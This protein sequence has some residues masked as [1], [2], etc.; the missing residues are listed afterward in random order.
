MST[1]NLLTGLFIFHTFKGMYLP[2]TCKTTNGVTPCECMQCHKGVSTL[3]PIEFATLQISINLVRFPVPHLMYMYK[4]HGM[5][6]QKTVHTTKTF[7]SS[8]DIIAEG[9]TFSTA[10]NACSVMRVCPLPHVNITTKQLLPSS[11]S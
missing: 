7:A 11:R 8:E 9:I 1:E 2:T 4:E 3:S 6:L 5:S 10:C